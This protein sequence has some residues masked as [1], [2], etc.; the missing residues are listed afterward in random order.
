MLTKIIK[1]R[2]QLSHL[3]E[4]MEEKKIYIEK[5]ISE[6]QQGKVEVYGLIYPG[7]AV[8]IGRAVLNV[9]DEIRVVS[10]V[11]EAGE[12]KITPYKPDK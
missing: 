10:L 8:Y 1:T 6:L 11:E 7:V 5:T 4:T 12:V 3:L 2:Q 9:K